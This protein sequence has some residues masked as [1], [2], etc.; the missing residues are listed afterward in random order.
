M[1]RNNN[2]LV[3]CRCGG[4]EKELLI[5]PSSANAPLVLIDNF[6]TSCNG[7]TTREIGQEKQTIVDQED[8]I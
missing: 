7:D 5:L 3:E 2:K 4:A 8:E 6:Q 1:I